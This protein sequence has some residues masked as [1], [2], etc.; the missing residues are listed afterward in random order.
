MAYRNY[1]TANGVI[2]AKDGNGDFSTIASALSAASSGDTIFIRPGT[3]TENITLKAGVNLTAFGSDGI[4]SGQGANITPNVI[5]KGTVT[6]SFTGS[7]TLCGIQ[8]ET[9][10][11]AALVNSGTNA[12]NLIL[13]NCSVYANDATGMNLTGTL[14]NFTFYTCCF[15]SSSTNS[16]F[17]V[18]GNI[19]FQSCIFGLSASAS[20]S[21]VSTA[22]ISLVACD[23]NGLF[24]TTSSTGMVTASGSTFNCGGNIFLTTAGTGTSAISS[25]F[26]NSTTASSLS[27]GAGTTIECFDSTISSSNTN[28][29]TGAGTIVYGGVVFSSTSSTIN[30]TTQT[31][32]PWPVK[33]GGT[34]DS[35]FTAY[36]VVCGGTSTTGALQNVS[37]VGSSTQVLTSNGAGMLPTWQNA[38][39]GGITTIDGDSGGGIT[40]STVT[41]Y[42]NTSS[43]NCGSSVSFSTSGTTSTLN[44]TD[45][46]SNTII[47][48][49]AGN[50]SVSGTNNVGVGYEALHGLTSGTGNVSI[51]LGSLQRITTGSDNTCIGVDAGLN[52][53]TGSESNN[54]LLGAVVLGTASESN[55][56]RIG[57]NG[58][59]SGQQNKCFV[60]GIAGITVTGSAVLC[61]ATGQL[62]D[63]SSSIRFKENIESIIDSSDL[64]GLNPVS[65]NYKYEEEKTLHYGLIAEE[66]DKVM[67]NL[68][69]YDKDNLPYS[70]KYHEMPALLLVE[71]KN[72]KSEIEELKKIIIK[73][74]QYYNR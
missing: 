31:P 42:A 21:T 19:D 38:A 62:G 70:I 49:L 2:V 27:A 69:I 60:A 35:S 53:S 8:L 47:G 34:G 11:A 39:A 59:G 37:G 68:V 45:S 50:S 56:I 20:A 6:A 10:G 33:Q 5:I 28:A 63:V 16:L 29:I 30:T 32:I 61:S 64:Y 12:A 48:G 25:C 46:S 74:D 22:N 72:L 15:N 14:T 7:A 71:I 36:S 67:P 54:I 52:Y 24:L 41:I 13:T 43:N 18:Y 73:N 58:S 66:V 44:V 26:I 23:S 51:G 55:V 17:T 4:A 40:G 9:N 1:S 57:N 65:F 3:Y